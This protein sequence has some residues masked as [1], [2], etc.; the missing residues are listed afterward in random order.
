MQSPLSVAA[1][2]CPQTAPVF[3]CVFA[4]VCV[5]GA[6]DRGEGTGWVG[7]EKRQTKRVARHMRARGATGGRRRRARL[8]AGVVAAVG[9][10]QV[11]RAALQV[12]EKRWRGER[13]D[14]IEHLTF[15]LRLP[16]T[17]I[18]SLCYLL[19]RVSCACLVVG[20]NE[21]VREQLL[22]LR[23]SRQVGAHKDALGGRG[24]G[25]NGRRMNRGTTLTQK[26][27]TKTHSYS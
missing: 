14:A 1:R 18:N 8:A 2:T 24:R 4:C 7:C 21:L 19:P 17:I 25:G 26:Q 22:Q 16:K 6:K 23:L 27:K 9:P 15:P 13:C 12:R 20:V 3:C 10:V 11:L 5:R